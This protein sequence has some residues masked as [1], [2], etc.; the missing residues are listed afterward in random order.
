VSIHLSTSRTRLTTAAR[1]GALAAVGLLAFAGCASTTSSAGATP[2]ASATAA[3]AG[4]VVTV[5]DAWVKAADSG[6][7]AAFGTLHNDSKSDVT[8]VSATSPASSMLQL[9]E[10]VTNAS[11]AMVMQE[12]NGGF[13]IPAGGDVVLKPGGN[14]I[15]L[16]N[17]AAPLKAGAETTF[18]L[19]F[20][21]G[22]TM[23]FSAPV[24]DYSGAN[25]NY[26]GGD[27]HMSPTPSH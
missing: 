19:T 3:R 10:T 6:M 12:K 11:G 25:E 18:T 13:V 5:S 21:D 23:E 15:M 16:M 1:V 2:S 22:S 4:A 17:L 20:S 26:Q 27:M 9:H 7:S 8:L 24:K 14:H